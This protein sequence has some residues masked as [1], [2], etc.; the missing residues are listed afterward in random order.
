M[1]VARGRDQAPL[2]ASSRPCGANFNTGESMTAMEPGSTYIWGKHRARRARAARPVLPA[3]RGAALAAA[4]GCAGARRGGTARRRRAHRRQQEAGGSRA[5]RARPSR[6]RLLRPGAQKAARRRPSHSP[7]VRAMHRLNWAR[8]H[9]RGVGV[10][11]TRQ[12][13]S[14]AARRARRRPGGNGAVEEGVGFDAFACWVVICA[15][16]GVSSPPLKHKKRAR[17][18]WEPACA[19]QCERGTGGA[20]ASWRQE[21]RGPMWAPQHGRRRGAVRRRPRL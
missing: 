9:Q 12:R 18:R 8:G 15:G 21:A 11:V 10:G 17:R 5:G 13:L 7:A 20:A 3:G 16:Q 14:A 19:S 1:H 6:L 2:G 4:R